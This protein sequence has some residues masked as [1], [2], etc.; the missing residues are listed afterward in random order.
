MRPGHTNPGIGG[1]KRLLCLTNIRT[2]FQQIRGEA[3]R[4]NRKV[5]LVNALA[6]DDGPRIPA[7]QLAYGMFLEGNLFLYL[8]N[9]G[10]GLFILGLDLVEFQL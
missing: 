10:Q 7:E 5:Q 9:R 6:P 4:S 3:R 1:D 2:F 8:R